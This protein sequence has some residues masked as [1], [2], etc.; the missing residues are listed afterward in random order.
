MLKLPMG[1]VPVKR[2]VAFTL[3][4]RNQLGIWQGNGWPNKLEAHTVAQL[5]I[6]RVFLFFFLFA[7]AKFFPMTDSTTL[8]L[9]WP[10]CIRGRQGRKT[11]ETFFGSPP[12]D[13][14]QLK[15]KKGS[16]FWP[17]KSRLWFTARADLSATAL[18][19]CCVWKLNIAVGAKKRSF[20]KNCLTHGSL[21]ALVLDT[22]PLSWLDC[23]KWCIAL[24]NDELMWRKYHGTFVTSCEKHAYLWPDRPEYIG[25]AHC[26]V[27]GR[28]NE[29]GKRMG[30]GDKEICDRSKPWQTYKSSV[31]GGCVADTI[32]YSYFH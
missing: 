3:L 28:G 32:T 31:V 26:A 27:S 20:G 19:L 2:R 30:R 16:S 12:L 25:M 8:E 4:S 17:A 9:T 11:A 22:S 5:K 7:H 18:F 6:S 24:T 15:G 1:R 29:D 23:H 21:H 13:V 14:L 10:L